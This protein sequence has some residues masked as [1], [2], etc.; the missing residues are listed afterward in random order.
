MNDS[1]YAALIAKTRL[2]AK[3]R[4]LVYKAVR[5]GEL[6]RRPC[7]V[8]DREPADAHH[9]DHERPLDVVWL[10]RLHHRWRHAYGETVNEMRQNALA[11]LKRERAA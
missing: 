1:E 8:C 10:C 11:A 2:Q 9:E 7:E 5:R 4:A 6:V 3:A